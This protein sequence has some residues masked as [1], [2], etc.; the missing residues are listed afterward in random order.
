MLTRHIARTLCGHQRPCALACEW[1]VATF[2]RANRVPPDC[3]VCSQDTLRALYVAIDEF[4]LFLVN[5]PDGSWHVA[6][7]H[8]EAV[9]A[10]QTSVSLCCVQPTLLL[11]CAVC[12]PD[13]AWHIAAL[14]GNA[15][16]A[17]QTS[18]SLCCIQ[19]ILL[20]ILAV[21]L[22]NGSAAPFAC[23]LENMSIA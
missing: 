10:C 4:A 1:H 9:T 5:M 21:R 8:A 3:W 18:V 16:T 23:C 14:H 13:G 20:F 19:P 12:L 22:P 7:L 15:V 6:R 11:I 2:P 17:W